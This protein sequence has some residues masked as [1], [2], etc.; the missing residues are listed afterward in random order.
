MSQDQARLTFRLPEWLKRQAKSIAAQQGRPLQDV[1]GELT[2]KWVRE[3]QSKA[4]PQTH[5]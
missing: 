1:L 2:E 5:Q 4:Q 3:Q